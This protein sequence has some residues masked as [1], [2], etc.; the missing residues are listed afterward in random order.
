[1]R[2]KICMIFVLCSSVLFAPIAQAEFFGLLNGRSGDLRTMPDISIDAGY[3]T[4]DYGIRGYDMLGARVNY[5]FVPGMIGY[6][7]FGKSDVGL[8]DGTTLGVGLYYQL[9]NLIPGVHSS[10]KGSIH[11]A[12]LS[13]TFSTFFRIDQDIDIISAEFLVGGM[14]P[15]MDNGLAWYANAGIHRLDSVGFGGSDTEPGVGAGITLP[16]GP[17]VAYFGADF[18]DEMMFGGGFR[19]KIR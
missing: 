7:D 15:L 2:N 16:V 5:R 10:I 6:V 9:Q 19:F 8:L 1:M 3:I 17:G 14:Q 11:R 13:G 4:G 12:S 18:I